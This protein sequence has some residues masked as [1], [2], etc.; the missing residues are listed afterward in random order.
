MIGEINEVL[1]RWAE[2]GNRA[3]QTGDTAGRKPY[4]HFMHGFPEQPA[5]DEDRPR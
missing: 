1:R 5:E 2:V 3:Q 4:V